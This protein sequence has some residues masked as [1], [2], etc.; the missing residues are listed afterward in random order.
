MSTQWQADG[1]CWRT[2]LRERVAA[3]AAGL[4]LVA[5]LAAGVAP[6]SAGRSSSWTPPDGMF[7]SEVAWRTGVEPMWDLGYTGAGIDVAVIDTGVNAVQ[8]LDAGGKIIDGPDFSF[9]ADD[10]NLRHRDL[11]GHGTAMASLVAGD[12][13]T[14][15]ELVG[16]NNL[17][18][19]MA[20]DAR[21]VNVKVGDGVGAVD[22]SQ[23][24]AAID[25]V[26]QHRNA[27]GMNIRVMLLAFDTDSTQDYLVDPLAYAV[28]NAW[29]H[30]IT[31]VVSAGNDGRSASTLGAPAIDPYVMAVSAVAPFKGSRWKVPN[32]A[33][34]GDGVRDPD[35]AMPGEQI[36]AAAVPGSYLVNAH[37]DAVFDTPNGPVIRG[38]GTSQAAALAAG[39]GGDAARGSSRPHPRPGQGRPDDHGQRCR[40]QRQVRRS[41]SGR[42]PPSLR[43]QRQRRRPDPPQGHRPGQPRSLPGQL[44]RR[45]P[46]RPAQ[47]GDHGLRRRLE[48][49]GVDRGHR[50]GCGLQRFHLVRRHLERR[51]VARGNLVRS[52]MVRSHMVRSHLVRSHLVRSHLVRSHL[53]RSHL[54][55]SHLVRSHLV[56]SHL[57][58]RDLVGGDLVRQHLELTSAADPNQNTPAAPVT[59]TQAPPA[60]K[61]G[62]GP[63]DG[64]KDGTTPTPRRPRRSRNA[65]T[66]GDSAPP[67]CIEQ[68]TPSTRRC[69]PGPS[70]QPSDSRPVE[71]PDDYWAQV[72]SSSLADA[73]LPSMVSPVSE[74]RCR[75][76][77]LGRSRS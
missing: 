32:W 26:V 51:L 2:S 19:G 40:Y 55:R 9:D 48:S 12:A 42:P 13:P 21:I 75:M 47:R 8:G 20:P 50:S 63:K 15:V 44:S 53:V 69:A 25:W 23:V 77:G 28:E 10:A 61:R 18:V 46:G 72:V 16:S 49:R 31:V 62:L 54:V 3:V 7:G 56:R 6:V 71:A 37:P 29:H 41:W 74:Q 22:V 60:R 66:C 27:N 76:L 33:S 43:H 64:K 4:A 68:S 36:L 11:Y 35:V 70:T 24:I 38:N 1:I 45:P 39:V 57:V 65:R 5:A 52:H 14:D 73:R 67:A 59:P 30:G 34:S 17:A 58:R